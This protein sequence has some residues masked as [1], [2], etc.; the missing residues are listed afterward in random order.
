[1]KGAQK[2][3]HSVRTSIFVGAGDQSFNEA[4]P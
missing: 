4:D 2:S 3:I 1:M